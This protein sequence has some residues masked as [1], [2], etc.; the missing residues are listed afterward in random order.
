VP[1]YVYRC[2]E[3]EEIFEVAHSMNHIQEE[4]LLCNSEKEVTRIP[5]PIG[6][7]VVEKA[8]KTGDIVKQYIKDASLDLRNDKKSSKVEYK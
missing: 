6:D 2:E 7:K 4:C 8:A 3:C 1:R 5:A